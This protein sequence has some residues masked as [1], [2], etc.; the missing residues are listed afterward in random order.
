MIYSS[1]T[2]VAAPPGYTIQE[3]L[4]IQEMTQEDFSLFMGMSLAQTN[5]LLNGD[6]ELT[7]EIAESLENVLGVPAYFWNNLE[8][9]YREKLKK[10]R[11]EN[12]RDRKKNQ[13]S[14]RKN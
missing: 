8:A 1:R 10:V 11:L 13:K 3:Q 2:F 6:I 7:P 14:N 4:D 5:Q 12:S 9:Y